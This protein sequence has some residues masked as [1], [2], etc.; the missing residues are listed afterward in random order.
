[1]PIF[2]VSQNIANDGKIV[3]DKEREFTDSGN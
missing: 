3:Y 1:M 2:A